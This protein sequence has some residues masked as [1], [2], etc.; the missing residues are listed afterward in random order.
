MFFA[1]SFALSWVGW[2]PLVCHAKLR[3][4]YKSVARSSNFIY[5]KTLQEERDRNDARG[6]KGEARRIMSHDQSS[7]V[8]AAELPQETR[9]TRKR[10]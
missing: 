5:I 7:V 3:L 2:V 4:G 8:Y 9:N 10:R 6:G 1:L